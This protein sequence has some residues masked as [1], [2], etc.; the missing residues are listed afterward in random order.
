MAIPSADPRLLRTGQY[1]D[2]SNLDARSSIY[3][4]RR[5]EFDLHGWVLSFVPEGGRVLD[6]GCGP[7]SYLERFARAGREQVIGMDLSAGMAIEA[8][9]H[10]PT[11]S[12]D[13]TALPFGDG[14]FDTTLAMHMLYHVDPPANGVAEL[15]RVTRPDGTMLA[16]TNGDRHLA[17]FDRIIRRAL[18]LESWAR[19]MF[20]FSLENGEEQILPHFAH[21][22]RV[23][24]EG[25][26]VVPHLEPVMAYIDSIEDF[27]GPQLD[28]SWSDAVDAMRPLVEA[29]IADTGA[30]RSTVHSGIFICR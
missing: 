30:F 2:S 22:E 21:V 25:E 27:L 13:I 7:G 6:A 18:G 15:R 26:L 4:F 23:D 9:R 1:V 11:G 17:G 19:S 24:V 3:A 14:V 8:A 28:V 16:V 5:P 10:A 20:R 29:E 12:A